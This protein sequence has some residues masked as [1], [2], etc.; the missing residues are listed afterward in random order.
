MQTRNH[1]RADLYSAEREKGLT[2]KQIAEKYGVSCQAVHSACAKSAPH[3]FKPYN[4]RQ[5]VYP[6]LRRWMND[7]KVSRRELVRRMGHIA[8]G[9]SNMN[10]AGWLRGE[11]YPNKQNIDLLLQVSG[12]TYEE[13]FYREGKGGECEEV[14]AEEEGGRLR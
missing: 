13:L 4:E 10:M 7:N 12:L 14:S 5:V 2:Y 11:T 3:L 8:A 1:P 9:R 6:F